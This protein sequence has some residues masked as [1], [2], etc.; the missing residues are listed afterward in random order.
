MIS[1]GVHLK[2]SPVC[3]G[4]IDDKPSYESSEKPTQDEYSA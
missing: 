4:I 2:N 1:Y 3:L